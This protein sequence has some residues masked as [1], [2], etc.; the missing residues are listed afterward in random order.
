MKAGQGTRLLSKILLPFKKLRS[1]FI[2]DLPSV[3]LHP[4]FL[5]TCAFLVF[6]G[7]FALV[8]ASLIA[9]LI[10]E[11][12]HAAEANRRGYRLKK[13]T[14]FPYGGIIEGDAIAPE[15]MAPIA[16][17]GPIANLV[18]ALICSSVRANYPGIAFVD[19][20]MNANVA[21]FA[22]NLL[23]AFPLDGARILSSI[24]KDRIK[25]L[26]ILRIVGI[27]CALVLFL[28]FILSAFGK[29]NLTFGIMA[30]FLFAGSTTGVG[31]EVYSHL[32][33]LSPLN[34]NYEQGVEIRR[35]SVSEKA[36]VSR[37]SALLKKGTLTEFCVVDTDGKPLKTITED[38]L[39]SIIMAFSGDTQIGVALQKDFVTKV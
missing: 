36:T 31:K 2:S 25:T 11:L 13:I 24:T 5:A 4:L 22:F 18:L 12:G 35:I 30:I 26:K 8:A 6:T 28:L 33:G 37:L 10:H 29:I 38:D 19:T 27:A 16:A 3:H 15:H 20:L 32:A 17:A 39:Y 9:V 21:V 34:K 7:G 1:S 14:L 23:P